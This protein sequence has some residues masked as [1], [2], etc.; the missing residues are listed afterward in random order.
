MTN[1]RVIENEGVAGESIAESYDKLM[2]NL[3]GKGYLK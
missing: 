3:M 2:K 1:P